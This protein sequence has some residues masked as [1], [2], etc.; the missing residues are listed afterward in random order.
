ML[1]LKIY[2]YILY[3]SVVLVGVAGIYIIS[4]IQNN[5]YY[6][7][8]SIW[9]LVLLEINLINMA[10]TIQNYMTNSKKVGSKGPKGDNGPRGFKG[11]NNICN[12]C[13]DQKLVKYGSDMNDFN[14][15]I[16]DPKLKIGQCVFPFVFDNEFQ[17]DCTT[18]ARTDGIEN[19]AMVNG[20]C[21]TEVNSDNTYK[22]YGYCKDSDKNE[23]KIKN[24]MSRQERERDYQTNNSGILDIKIV[25]GVRTN[26]KCPPK[27]KKIDIDLNLMAN[28]NFV[29]LCR[30]D[31]I[32]DSGV[33][34]IKLTT[35]DIGCSPGFR[36]LDKNLNDG[37]PDL[38][39]SDM[40]EVCVKKGSSKFIRDI[41][42]E[43]TKK[44]PKDYK[45]Q[46]IN[47]NKSVGGQELYMCTS[48]TVN[49]GIIL[50]SAFIWGG[51]SNLYFF[52]DD[53]YWKLNMNSYKVEKG[54]PDKISSFWGKIPKNIDAV[55]TNPHDKHTYFFKGSVFYK[56]DNKN[57]KIAKGYPKKIKDVW[58]NVP[59]NLD[60]VYVDSDKNVF[61]M[62]EDKYYEWNESEKR[63]NTPL[64]INRRWVDA[65]SNINGMFYNTKKEQ[66]YI[67]QAN[68][69][70][71]FNFDM[72]QD[73]SSP[74]DINSEFKDVK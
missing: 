70:Y 35:G 64:L 71:K 72:K 18:A 22:T 49:Q 20:W 44:C 50:D 13:G 52:K 8:I 24:N 59:D 61:F 34:D 62:Y 65:P 69:I 47:L 11:R 38:S 66:T 43:K 48:K 58:K 26:V 42:I 4:R 29:Y 16:E 25:S 28:G 51:D 10:F 56:Y 55:F 60:A 27:Y 63:A 12:Q 7:T 2:L 31:G 37:F 33:Q 6:K 41:K 68:K 57:E 19:D 73:S 74:I 17:Y 54:Y 36:K 67:I 9:L 39:P 23:T 1:P 15:K 5:Q 14:N 32:G 40:V 3:I 53:K 46:D 21:A 45:L 30:K